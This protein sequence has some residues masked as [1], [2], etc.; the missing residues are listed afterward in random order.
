MHIELHP[1]PNPSTAVM[2]VRIDAK[3]HRLYRTYGFHAEARVPYEN[4][5]SLLGSL[6][7]RAQPPTLDEWAQVFPNIELCGRHGCFRWDVHDRLLKVEVDL[8]NYDRWRSD[9]LVLAAPQELYRLDGQRF[10]ELCAWIELRKSAS[11][12]IGDSRAWTENKRVVSAGR[13]ESNPHRH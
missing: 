8:R 1:R 13:F 5:L 11:G 6:C 12:R 7:V 3:W 9:R 4:G 2:C 10:Y